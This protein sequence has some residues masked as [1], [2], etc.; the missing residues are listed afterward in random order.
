MRT[1]QE[2][3]SGAGAG[4]GLYELV[5]ASRWILLAVFLACALAGYLLSGLMKRAYRADAVVVPVQAANQGLMSGLTGLLGSSALAG[6]GL[7]PSADKNE[8]KETLRSRVLLRQYIDE[9]GLLR[10][11]C[12][13]DAIDC[14]PG[15]TKPELDAERQMDD[16]IKLFRDDLLSVDEDTLTGVIHVS[17]TWYDRVAAAQWCNGLIDL[18][19]QVMQ[20]KTRA[21][22]ASRIK[23]LRQEYLQADTVNLQTSISA[24]LQTE[25]SRAADASSRPEYALRIVDPAAAPDDRYPVRPRKAVI[26]AASGIFGAIV[27]LVVLRV[28]RRR[29]G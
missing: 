8:A 2:Q 27:A 26:G 3:A 4:G 9:H 5:T 12:A 17:V 7:A 1:R 15:A 24:L 16:A 29:T 10:Q 19:N 18:T 22:A 11:L 13:T 6:L 28:R 23:F 20:S 21:V 14:K 25:L